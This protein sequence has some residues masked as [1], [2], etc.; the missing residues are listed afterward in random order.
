MRHIVHRR[1]F[2]TDDRAVSEEFT[3]LPALCIVMIG[4]ALFTV[5]IAQTYIAYQGRVDSIQKYQ[6]ASFLTQKLTNPECSFMR[7]GTTVDISQLNTPTSR[8]QLNVTRCVYRQSGVDFIV[9][10]R[11]NNGSQ[12]F[13]INLPANTSNRVA[14]SKNVDVYLNIAQTIPGTL[15]VITW[16]CAKETSSGTPGGNSGSWGTSGFELVFILCALAFFVLQKQ[17]VRRKKEGGR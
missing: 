14:V 4:F 9:R 13:P 16:S 1:L 15:T 2:L 11:W 3:T 17:N 12:D 7:T 10:M 6:T 5:L 8:D